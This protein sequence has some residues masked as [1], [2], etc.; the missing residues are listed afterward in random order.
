MYTS[1]VESSEHD[2]VKD[3][4]AM[5]ESKAPSS[6][7]KAFCESTCARARCLPLPA[8]LITPVQRIPRYRLLVAEYVKHTDHNH[9]DYSRLNAAL[10]QIKATAASVNESIRAARNRRKIVDLSSLFARNPGFVAP[11]RVYRCDGDL[12]KKCRKDDRVYRFFL[13]DDLLAYAKELATGRYRLH[14]KIPVDASFAVRDLPEDT[15]ADPHSFQII[16]CVK[17]FQVYARTGHEKAAWLAALREVARGYAARQ[18]AAGQGPAQGNRKSNDVPAVT[19]RA[20]LQT[21]RKRYCQRQRRRDGMPCASVF[22]FFKKRH[23]CHKCGVLCCD[24]CSPYRLF[25]DQGEKKRHRVCTLCVLPL[26]HLVRNYGAYRLRDLPPPESPAGSKMAHWTAARVDES[27]GSSTARS[28]CLSSGEAKEGTLGKGPVNPSCLELDTVHGTLHV[29]LVAG[30]DLRVGARHTPDPYVVLSAPGGGEARTDVVKKT[31]NP[32]WNQELLV[33]VASAT[34]G[35][36]S[37]RVLDHDSS[38]KHEPMGSAILRLAPLV[39]DAKAHSV[40]VSLEL[41]GEPAGVLQAC[42]R[43]APALRRKISR[44][45]SR[46]GGHPELLSTPARRVQALSPPPRSSA[47]GRSASSRG[48]RVRSGSK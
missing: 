40:A 1:Y 21:D 6:P 11:A 2:R 18:S 27:D 10:V 23:N 22:G 9:P 4:M 36:V 34:A 31:V 39:A 33:Y 30:R 24:E 46:G 29:T 43:F 3:L 41:D 15:T 47:S 38:S 32:R 35:P 25:I 7:F 26:M 20:V 12:V 14:R 48:S 13:F 5:L 28:S 16:N 37:L 45:K 8:L 19:A 17:S 44:R 42:V